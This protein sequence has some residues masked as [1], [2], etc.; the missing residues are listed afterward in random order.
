MKDYTQLLKQEL[1]PAMGCTEPIAIALCAAKAVELLGQPLEKMQVFCSGNI[2]KN[3]KSVLVPHG[4]GL[5]GIEA[6]AALGC[7]GGKASLGLEVLRDADQ[8]ALLQAKAFIRSGAIS[9]HHAK[10]IESL[11]IRIIVFAKDQSAEAHISRSHH[12][13]SFLRHNETILLQEQEEPEGMALQEELNFQDILDFSRQLETLKDAELLK[14]LQNQADCNLLIAREGLQGDYGASIG[15]TL[16]KAY[17]GQASARLR[18]YASAGSD[19]RMAG[20]PMTVVINS[21]SGNQGMTVSLPLVIYAQDHSMPD[22]KLFQALALSN[23]LAI[24]MK[25]L[26]GKMSA[27]C[28]VVS[29]AAGAGAGLCYLQGKGADDMVQVI[30]TTLLTSGGIFCDG[31]KASCASKIAIAIENALLAIEMQK[32]GHSLPPQQGLAGRDIDETI[33]NIGRA[34]KEGMHMTDEV[35]LDIMINP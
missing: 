31:A 28:G 15:K 3:V 12:H 20:S 1:L 30:A 17:P 6:A 27:F 26:I 14:L 5:Y 13:F 25:T 10:G 24:Y 7:F 21:G 16:L 34:A 32:Q 18:A 29:A 11:F 22:L 35:I 19:A 23:L 33:L 4:E 2:I 9:V 8:P